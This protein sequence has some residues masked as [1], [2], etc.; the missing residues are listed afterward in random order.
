MTLQG[1]T[2]TAAA[3][4]SPDWELMTAM[5]VAECQLDVSRVS[6]QGILASTSWKITASLRR[7]QQAF[8]HDRT[9]GAR[10]SVRPVRGRR[11]YLHGYATGLAE[12]QACAL[13]EQSLMACDMLARLATEGRLEY[14]ELLSHPALGITPDPQ[15]LDLLL[16][17]PVAVPYL[18]RTMADM[19][20]DA[21]SHAGALALYRHALRVDGMQCWDVRDHVPFV[22]LLTRAGCVDEARRHL[23]DSGLEKCEPLTFRCLQ[24]NLLHPR[25]GGTEPAWL[26]AMNAWYRRAHLAPISLA[27]SPGPWLDRL[28]TECAKPAAIS[29]APL[30]SVLMTVYSDSPDTSLD[31]AI[32]SVLAQTWSNLELVIVD[33]ASPQPTHERLLEWQQRD[34]RV[35]VVRA[36]GNLGAYACRNLGM[37]HVQGEFVTCHDADD[38]SHPQKIEHQVRHLMRHPGRMANLSSWARVTSSMEFERFSL[39]SKMVYSNLSSLMFRR[40]PVWERLGGWDEV[41]SAADSEF[42]QRLALV[43]GHEVPVLGDAPLSFGRLHD[44]SL[45][46]DTLGKGHVSFARRWYRSAWQTWHADLS[47]GDGGSPRLVPGRDRVFTTGGL[48]A[49]HRAGSV[50]KAN[51]VVMADFCMEDARIEPV[52]SCIKE[53]LREGRRPVLCQVRTLHTAAIANT[54]AASRLQRLVNRFGLDVIEL[55]MPLEADEIFVADPRVLE[56]T[57]Y[58]V[59]AIRAANVILAWTGSKG[60]E[61]IGLEPLDRDFCRREVYRLFSVDARDRNDFD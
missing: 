6:L 54:G 49:R 9:P 44:R 45:T 55:G 12:L 60:P 10:S 61:G 59:S 36:P 57:R 31:T 26:A 43:F 38:W 11:R 17:N 25:H 2:R 51:V 32:G 27:A 50:S 7:L 48:L 5:H 4:L 34:V 18:A 22:D 33:D 46:H 58:Q 40:R 35:R 13:A 14:H 21:G 24:I 41:R 28:R 3:Q 1:E 20:G 19:R 47:R 37:Q 16:T 29:R 15:P 39:D 52:I 42:C 8:R 53:Q 23:S 56:F 30:V